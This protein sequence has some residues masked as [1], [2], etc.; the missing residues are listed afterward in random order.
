M[1]AARRP[2]PSTVTVTATTAPST[3]DAGPDQG[4]P[5]ACHAP[6]VSNYD[7]ELW[8]DLFVATAGAGAALAGLV[9]VAVSINISQ[10][11]LLQGVP[12]RALQTVLLLLASVVVSVFGLVPQPAAALAVETIGVGSA[13][14]A[15]FAVSLRPVLAGTQGHLPWIATRLVTLLPGSVAYVV[16]GVSLL[17]GQGG[18]LAWVVVGIVG[19][20][21]GAIVN[22]W[23]LLVEILR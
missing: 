12:E 3:S 22:A 2:E 16:A 4:S 10:I 5:H 20:F 7:A 18:G 11:L 13:L 17:I 14:V 8:H 15:F 1:T 6:P 23:V 9:F 19:A 21:L